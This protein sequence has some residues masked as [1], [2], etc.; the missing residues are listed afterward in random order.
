MSSW[1]P[2]EGLSKGSFRNKGGVKSGR[3]YEW[4]LKRPY[5]EAVLTR[6]NCLPPLAPLA[7]RQSIITE[8]TEWVKDLARLCRM[9]P[10]ESSYRAI[11]FVHVA[12]TKGCL[13]AMQQMS[14]FGTGIF[15]VP[16]SVGQE[17]TELFFPTPLRTA[18]GD[19]LNRAS[20]PE[21]PLLSAFVSLRLLHQ[22]CGESPD[23][24]TAAA[25]LDMPLIERFHT[26]PP[27]G[28]AA[29]WC[30][31]PKPLKKQNEE[32]RRP[33]LGPNDSRR[34]LPLRDGVALSPRPRSLNS[35]LSPP[36]IPH[37]QWIHGPSQ[38]RTPGCGSTS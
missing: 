31:N 5:S 36:G 18:A 17:D 38:R 34:S 26:G 8:D 22:G 16:R 13:Y 25:S 23:V 4:V 30:P 32:G 12:G 28:F 24:L 14:T 1:S 7:G 21:C 33:D 11:H 9:A 10:H 2:Q 3:E 19:R 6:S 27:E 20:A 37:V 35:D 15:A 29:G